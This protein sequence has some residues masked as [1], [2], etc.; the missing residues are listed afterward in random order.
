MW[1]PQ[2]GSILPAPIAAW[3]TSNVQ[4]A[5][6]QQSPGMPG[7]P[8]GLGMATGPAISAAPFGMQALSPMPPALA[9]GMLPQAGIPPQMPLG[10]PP[11]LPGVP[12]AGG[13]I[14]QLGANVQ[15]MMAWQTPEMAQAL[16]QQAAEAYEL[17]KTAGM[18]P[19]VQELSEHFNLDERVAKALNQQMKNRK[20]TYEGDMQ[21]LWEVLEGARNPSGLLM[22]KVREMMDGKF[23]GATD[24]DNGLR[25]WG[26]KY[27]LDEQAITKLAEVLAKRDDAAG[28]MEKIGKHLERSNKPSSL[29]M[30]ML[31]DLRNGKPVPEPQHSAAVGSKM[32]EKEL[33]ETKSDRRH[34]SRSGRRGRSQD[35]R[36][37]RRSPSRS[38]GRH[39]SRSRGRR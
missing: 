23:R 1:E 6:P 39:R 29:M 19:E 22:V 21:T 13:H 38:R 26:K 14:G 8:R 2:P 32:H 27:K 5:V 20:D 37:R 16:T 18:D 15:A 33:K 24:P 28:D 30:L 36:G 11:G 34:R 10:L 4:A 9:S 35:R 31:R 3:D 17:E 7:L 25:A 12:G